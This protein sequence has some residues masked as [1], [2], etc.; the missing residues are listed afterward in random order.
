MDDKRCPRCK[1]VNPESAQ[2]CD[3]GYD[4]MKG[5]G[6]DNDEQQKIAENME[7]IAIRNEEQKIPE[8]RIK[9]WG[10]PL[11]ELLI[12]LLAIPFI[13]Y[14]RKYLGRQG[15]QY[16]SILLA[17]IFARAMKAMWAIAFRK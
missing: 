4:F 12:V 6:I 5:I 13:Y 9:S 14:F 11:G 15:T 7:G 1:L 17:L 2:R 10:E 3:C 16:A 8:N